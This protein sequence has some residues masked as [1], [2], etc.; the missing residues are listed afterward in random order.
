MSSFNKYLMM[1]NLYKGRVFHCRN[2][3]KK[4]HFRYKV[5][6]LYF[7]LLKVEKVFKKIPIFSIDK[8][9]LLSFYFKDH[10]P[11][12]EKN[13]IL[14]I[15]RAL[16]KNNINGN[17]SNIFLLTF[18]RYLGYVFN[19]LS[20]Y[21]CIDSNKKVVAQ[22]YEVHNTFGQRHFYLV[23]NAFDK[24]NHSKKIKK[25]F[26]VSPFI[27]MKGQYNFKSYSRK[28]K[29][30]IFIYYNSKNEDLIASFTGISK[31]ITNLNLIKEFFLMPLMT[32]KIIS[33]IHYEALLLF[34][35]GIKFYKCPKESKN[36]LSR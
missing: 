34:L 28:D 2:K 16:K 30:S 26:H 22:I 15:K 12:K 3:P 27:G 17:I 6:Y 21:T 11:K 20:V 14:W 23:K 9:N 13:L 29:L 8:F 31:K 4:H 24:K 35:K 10:G 5:F 36:N 33:G 32:L 18:P 19:P 1:N 7:D 25:A